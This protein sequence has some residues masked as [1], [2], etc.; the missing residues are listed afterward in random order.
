M[1]K[2]LESNI[3]VPNVLN[4]DYAN[5]AIY[6]EFIEGNTVKAILKAGELQEGMDKERHHQSNANIYFVSNILMIII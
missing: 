6:L 3:A 1:K 2:C 5:S 4:V